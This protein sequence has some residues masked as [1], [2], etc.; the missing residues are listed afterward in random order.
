ME[1]D[2]V[3]TAYLCMWLAVIGAVLG[4]FLDC[5]ADRWSR[6]EDWKKGRSH[7]TSCGH[8]LGPGDCSLYSVMCGIGDDAGT[9]AAGSRENAC[10]QNWPERRLL[11]VWAYDLACRR[12]WDS[13]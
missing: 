1:A 3:W 11:S 10:M 6:G 9:A 13:G 8:L 4:S 2:S 7:C 5:A 12:N